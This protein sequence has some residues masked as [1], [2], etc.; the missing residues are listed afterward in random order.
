M[1]TLKV[2]LNGTDVWSLQQILQE[3]NLNPG[4]LDLI[5]GKQ[6]KAAVKQFQRQQ[7]ITEDG[8]VGPLTWEKLLEAI[9]FWDR[10]K[11]QIDPPI[12]ADICFNR[13]VVFGF[14]DHCKAI[15]NFNKAIQLKPNFV[16]AYY[17]R[18]ITNWY[19]SLNDPESKQ[20]VI[21][22][23][24]DAIL[25]NPDYA[26]AYFERGLLH[27][28]DKNQQGAI[29]DWT[30]VIR[31][32][33]D[34]AEAY[35]RRGIA[36]DDVGDSQRAIE[37][38]MQVFGLCRGTC[39]ADVKEVIQELQVVQLDSD[40]AHAYYRG[41]ASF[42]LRHNLN[43]RK[44]Y[45][46]SGTE[47]GNPSYTITAEDSSQ[48]DLSQAIRLATNFADAYYYRG[49]CRSD[50]LYNNFDNDADEDFSQ[51]IQLNSEFVSAYYYR[52][53]QRKHEDK[54]RAIEDFT[55]AIQRNPDFALPYYH[56]GLLHAE[57]GNEKGAIADYRQYL[58][59]D[60]DMTEA[61]QFG[62]SLEEDCPKQKVPENY[63]QTL[64]ISPEDAEAYTKRGK[65]RSW[66]G[67]KK[68]AIADFSQA[69]ERS[70][71]FAEAYY[72]RGINY[73]NQENYQAAIEDFSRALEKNSHFAQ[74][75][76]ERGCA[77]YQ[78]AKDKTDTKLILTIRDNFTQ[79]INTNHNFADAYY[80]RGAIRKWGIDNTVSLN[81]ELHNIIDNQ[82]FTQEEIEDF[83][84]TIRINPYFDSAYHTWTRIRNI[85]PNFGDDQAAIDNLTEVI[86]SKPQDVDTYLQRGIALFTSRDWQGAIADFTEVI[87][88]NPDNTD[89]YYGRGLIYYRLQNYTRAIEDFTQAM[90]FESIFAELYALRGLARYDCGDLQ[91]A[92]EDC[93]QAIWLDPFN[94]NA[95]FIWACS[96]YDLGDTSVTLKDFM[97]TW[98]NLP[99]M[100]GR[101]VGDG[102]SK[103]TAN[104]K[105]DIEIRNRIRKG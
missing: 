86:S 2:G 91:G 101:G 52:G 66:L 35:Y 95:S 10:H 53:Y 24:T 45:I 15:G 22:D 89:A 82:S 27:H 84:Q 88:I 69:I 41:V 55:Q 1:R 60:P 59:L 29:H 105:A 93:K 12:S 74:A 34:H 67:D 94:V 39:K 33:P 38:Y 21:E 57:L 13:G 76:F 32:Q 17:H 3:L 20:Q 25:C 75:Y 85:C 72:Y 47:N 100:F 77:I 64:E 81:P 83:K 14:K 102:G 68:G 44:G 40:L 51:A 92:I 46:I 78:Q 99:Q 4:S 63:L 70:P 90:E 61:A 58:Y 28:L 50:N 8:I 65:I 23:F 49:R 96:C 37:D 26:A 54:Q 42:Y 80:F 9:A 31:I 71:Q 48:E 79:A 87:R 97:I 18:G 6:T 19:T 7:N 5:F 43:Y 16:E 30:E 73:V 104:T 56:R 62:L 36:H 98:W 103:S 11:L